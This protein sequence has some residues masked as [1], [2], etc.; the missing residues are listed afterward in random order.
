MFNLKGIVSAFNLRLYRLKESPKIFYVNHV[1]NSILKE[2]C[3]KKEEKYFYNSI[4]QNRL[5]RAHYHLCHSK[6]EARLLALSCERYKIDKSCIIKSGY[7]S[8]DVSLQ[9][10]NAISPILCGGGANI[11]L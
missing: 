10:Y 7:P 2:L 9:S 6:S 8:F 3:W 1:F 11:C 5:H 4:L